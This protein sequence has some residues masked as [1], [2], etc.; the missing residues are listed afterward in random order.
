MNKIK[1][2]YFKLNNL[3]KRFDKVYNWIIFGILCL[4]V[5]FF[6][7][8]HEPFR[9]EVQAWNIARDLSVIDIFNQMF[10]EGHPCL[11]HLILKPLTMLGFPVYSMTWVSVIIMLFTAWLILFK[12]PFSK[13]VRTILV[14]SSPFLYFYSIIS[15]SYCLIA[16]CITLLCLFYNKR[17]RHPLLYG[18]LIFFLFNTHVIMVG[19]ASILL[20]FFIVETFIKS[21][22]DKKIARMNVL[23][24]FIGFLGGI[25]LCIQIIGSYEANSLVDVV[26]ADQYG[27]TSLSEYI[28]YFITQY[29]ME[30]NYLTNNF[31]SDTLILFI[32]GVLLLAVAL[33]L[34]F[35]CK[36]TI[37]FVVSYLFS[38]F[39]CIFLFY[40]IPSRT[41][42]IIFM[43]MFWAWTTRENTE[44]R[45]KNKVMNFFEK[46]HICSYLIQFV[47][48]IYC[49]LSI[50]YGIECAENDVNLLMTDAPEIA[51]YIKENISK[52]AI[53]LSP[54]ENLTTVILGYIPG[55]SFYSTENER[56][57]TF[58]TWDRPLNASYT[59]EDFRIL[60]QRLQKLEKDI[61]IVYTPILSATFDSIPERLEKQKRAELVYQSEKEYQYLNS[62]Q[63]YVKFY[64]YKVVG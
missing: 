44:Y 28:S 12:S 55:Y 60:L 31:L 62:A 61:Y 51:E 2:A 38:L 29:R 59:F 1:N 22:H 53:I 30:Y 39:V 52:D 63:E 45:F 36:N 27:Y 16:L 33:G 14:F 37:V 9:D 11:W 32:V 6:A 21:L 26:G 7:L 57:F 46:F 25:V 10:S 24:C 50:P 64:I 35:K 15:R 49:L 17:E 43:L 42:I 18:L 23:G 54:S 4:I 58:I 5:I 19:M 56:Y 20:F 47:L 13:H 3:M 8:H 41:V 34:I 40:S 48:M